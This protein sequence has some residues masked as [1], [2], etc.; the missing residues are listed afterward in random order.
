MPYKTALWLD[1]ATLE[2]PVSIESAIEYANGLLCD[3]QEARAARY[4]TLRPTAQKALLLELGAL[5]IIAYE[6]ELLSG[7]T[8]GMSDALYCEDWQKPE[9]R[10]ALVHYIDTSRPLFDLSPELTGF[11]DLLPTLAHEK[12][13]ALTAVE[14][15]L[16]ENQRKTA[17]ARR[18]VAEWLA[19]IT[20]N[21]VTKAKTNRRAFLDLPATMQ[22]LRELTEAGTPW[23]EITAV[24]GCY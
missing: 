19:S 14:T 5:Q 15:A 9:T 3:Q 8:D 2:R 20:P 1:T 24:Y 23:N 21:N 22:Q 17:A 10:A 6:L 4:R 7:F 16:P 18:D 12:G 11:L 13:E